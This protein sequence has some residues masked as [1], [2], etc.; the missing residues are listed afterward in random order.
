MSPRDRRESPGSYRR[1]ETTRSLSRR[2][3]RILSAQEI[4]RE[5]CCAARTLSAVLIQNPVRLDL[6]R[7]EAV[8]QRIVCV[9]PALL[10]DRTSRL[11]KLEPR[12]KSHVEHEFCE[13][14]LATW[15]IEIRPLTQRSCLNGRVV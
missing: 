11:A 15:G 5:P 4:A 14:V 6:S 1:S 10:L 3:Y 7:P 9:F 13:R 8:E 2:S 12:P